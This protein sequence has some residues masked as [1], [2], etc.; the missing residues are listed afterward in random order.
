MRER[1]VRIS[2]EVRSG[3]ARFRVGVQAGSVHEAL[4]LVG[5]RYP[6]G[7]IRL[8]FPVEPP[9]FFVERPSSRTGIVGAGRI[10]RNAA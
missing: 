7:E 2:V 5:G 8:M 1:T 4:G 3:T 6:Q 10:Y 9:G